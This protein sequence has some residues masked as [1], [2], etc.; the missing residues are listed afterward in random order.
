MPLTHC[1]ATGNRINPRY[2]T[3]KYNRLLSEATYNY[4]YDAEG[5]HPKRTGIATRAVT[6]YVCDHRK[7]VV[8][9][10][11]RATEGG[12]AMQPGTGRA[13]PRGAGGTRSHGSIGGSTG[14]RRS[15][16][17]LRLSAN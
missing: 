12:A 13:L 7:R 16:R 14:A 3:G 4:E 9:V 11:E 5:N 2:V 6:E 17:S 8:A 15:M 10:V 1:D